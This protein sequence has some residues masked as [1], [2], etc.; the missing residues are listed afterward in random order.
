MAANTVPIFLKE[1]N[2]VGVLIN[3]A[4]TAADGS[5]TLFT[6]L[7]ATLDGSRIEGVNFTSSQATVG[8][9]VA[10]VCRM[11]ITDASGAN[12]Y[13]IGEVVLPAAT[14]SATAIGATAIFWFAK[15]K[16]LISGQIVKVSQS[17]CATAADNTTA[18]PIGGGNY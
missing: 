10:K 13:L 17:L 1:G 8:A 3:A 14:R 2:S 5:G 4:N 9:S 15:P 7:T 16:V 6:L 18:F 11:F 12:P